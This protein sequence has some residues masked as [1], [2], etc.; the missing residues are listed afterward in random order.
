MWNTASTTITAGGVPYVVETKRNSGE[1]DADVLAR[2]F[3][4]V[5]L[6]V[7][8]LGDPIEGPITTTLT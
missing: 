2:H 8:T 1:T 4:T 7:E 6:F 5:Y 3:K